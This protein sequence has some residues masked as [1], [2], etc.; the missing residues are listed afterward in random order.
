MKHSILVL[1]VLQGAVQGHAAESH[2][3]TEQGLWRPNI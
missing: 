1:L 2:A 3:D